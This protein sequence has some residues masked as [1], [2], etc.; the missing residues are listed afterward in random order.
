M[1]W[2]TISV[3]QIRCI[4]DSYCK[5]QHSRNVQMCC[6]HNY[7]QQFLKVTKNKSGTMSLKINVF[8]N[9]KRKGSFQKLG[10]KTNPNGIIFSKKAPTVSIFFFIFVFSLCLNHTW[11]FC[12]NYNLKHILLPVLYFP[13]SIS[14]CCNPGISF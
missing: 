7:F 10:V 13:I 11:F 8:P 9:E 4:S 14:L 12:C 3:T 6:S 5:P 1:R 2:E